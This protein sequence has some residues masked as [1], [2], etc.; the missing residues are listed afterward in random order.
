M[1]GTGKPLKVSDLLQLRL[2]TCQRMRARHDFFNGSRLGA[3]PRGSRPNSDEY[4]SAVS[5]KAISSTPWVIG[6]PTDSVLWNQS[7]TKAAP[8][9][10]YERGPKWNASLWCCEPQSSTPTSLANSA[11]LSWPAMASTR[12]N[13]VGIDALMPAL[14]TRA[15]S[16]T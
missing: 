14:E 10:A 6:I 4:T 13:A 7:L 8:Y 12:A 2:T 3:G 11:A 15:R 5:A 9:I 1:R 16:A